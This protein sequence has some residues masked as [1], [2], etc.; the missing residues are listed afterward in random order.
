MHRLARLRAHA[1][2]QAG[3]VSRTQVY[4]LGVTRSFVRANVRAQ[5]WRRIGSQSISLVTGPLT[6]QAQEWAAVFEAGPRAFLDGTSALIASGLVGYREDTIRVS[7]PRGARVRRARGL[8]IRQTRRWA[9]DDVV[10][11]GVPRSRPTVAAI[12]GAL[13]AASDRQAALVLTMAVQQGL[14]TAEQLAL[15][16]PPRPPRPASPVPARRAARPARWGAGPR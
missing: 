16:M 15:E 1:A 7:V 13:W 10:G 3:V 12:R 9:A 8:D 4:A 5:R 6:R 2:G 11:T 14:A